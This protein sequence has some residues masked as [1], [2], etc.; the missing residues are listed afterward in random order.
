[1]P[2]DG[3]PKASKRPYEVGYG[4]PP[5]ATRFGQRPQPQRRRRSGKEEPPNIAAI[6]ER[7]LE[8]KIDGKTARLHLHEAMLNGLFR[9]AVKGEL[10]AIQQFLKMCDSAGLLQPQAAAL[11]PVLHLP[12][13]IPW[14]LACYILMREGHP[15]WRPSLVEAYLAEYEADLAR[16]KQLEEVDRADRRAGAKNVS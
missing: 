14:E 1:M 2:N 8:A 15:P 16:L 13:N 12:T 10:R 6:L 5:K 4:R 7:P 3:K 9:R 11:G